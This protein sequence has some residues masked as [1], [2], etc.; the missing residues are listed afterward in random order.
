MKSFRN[1]DKFNSMEQL[2][3]NLK[4]LLVDVFGL[5]GD[6]SVRRYTDPYEVS[7]LSGM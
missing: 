5:I 4:P 3:I 1:L 2:W 7:N 6:G